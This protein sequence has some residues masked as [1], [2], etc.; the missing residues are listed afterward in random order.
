[1]ILNQNQIDSIAGKYTL[2]L[3]QIVQSNNLGERLGRNAGSS[4]EFHDRKDFQDGDDLRHID[5][6]GY[7]RNDRL[8]V[9]LYRQEIA[10][11]VEIIVDGSASMATT[12]EKRTRRD[13]IASLFYQFSKRI[14]ANTKLN[15]VS[16]R[17]YQLAN[18][19]D[20]TSYDNIMYE[21]PIPLI[22]RNSLNSGGGIKIIISDFL[23]EFDPT[24]IRTLFGAADRT[25]LIQLLSDFENDPSENLSKNS[26]VRLENSESN[27]YLD[28][29]LTPDN[30][31]HYLK[32]LNALKRD[33]NDAARFIR[34]AFV[35][36]T[37]NETLEEV[38]SKLLKS[39]I[40]TL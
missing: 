22:R 11:K 1:M 3:P 28:V 19:H 32:R 12:D 21:S 40:V 34:G 5:W 25:V 18:P 8:T 27:D 33:L 35:S 10:P 26:L 6:R 37:E 31:K 24:E 9:K 14:H 13:E 36:I 30:V 39:E 23:F 16:D 7:A 20:L 2:A 17:L 29:K 38:M 15:F 4:V